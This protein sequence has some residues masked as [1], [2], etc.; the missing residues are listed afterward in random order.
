MAL[1]TGVQFAGEY[2][3]GECKL[4]SSTG[5]VAR[6]NDSVAEINI[7]ENM[8]TTSLMLS[9]IIV[10]KENIVM[11][12]PIIGQEYVSLK[13]T[14]KGVGSFDFT[15]NVFSVFKVSSRQDASAGTQIFELNCVS[16]E[17]ITEQ[18]HQ[19]PTLGQIQK[20]LSLF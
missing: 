6:L 11:N 5:V 7:F 16:T 13:L 17:E 2:Q 3:L 8:F 1:G 18:E 10:D 4:L 14:T 15:D 9:L 12:M 20:L 19:N